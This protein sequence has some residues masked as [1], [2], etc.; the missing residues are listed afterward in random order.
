VT[1]AAPAPP[2]PRSWRHLEHPRRLWILAAAVVAVLG[3]V[4]Y[5]GLVDSINYYDTVNVALAN[6]ANLGSGTFNL[7]GTV[8]PG[9]VHPTAKGVDFTI[10]SSGQSMRVVSVGSAP[11]M[12]KPGIPVVVVGHFAGNVFASNQIVVKHSATYAAAN[13]ATATPR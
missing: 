12:F 1:L 6:R 4:L 8:L 5:K 13:Q 11:Q 9:T 10:S 3:F 2:R 7:E